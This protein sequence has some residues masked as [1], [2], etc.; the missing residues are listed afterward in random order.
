MSCLEESLFESAVTTAAGV[1]TS[2]PEEDGSLLPRELIKQC[3]P[4]HTFKCQVLKLHDCRGPKGGFT[5]H[6]DTQMMLIVLYERTLEAIS[7]V[8]FPKID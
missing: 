2:F 7:V 4:G 3:L 6:A 8:Y 1:D 5:K